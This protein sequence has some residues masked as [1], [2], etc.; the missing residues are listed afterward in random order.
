MKQVFAGNG[1][2]PLSSSWG[3]FFWGGA[4]PRSRAINFLLLVPKIYNISLRQPQ[5]NTLTLATYIRIYIEFGHYLTLYHN[6][7]LT[8]YRKWACHVKQQ[9]PLH[10]HVERLIATFH[11]LTGS[12]DW[13]TIMTTSTLLQL[14]GM[15]TWNL[16]WCTAFHTKT[17]SDRAHH[18]INCHKEC[19]LLPSCIKTMPPM[20]R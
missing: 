14:Y 5:N 11:W 2:K 3:S 6:W 8:L 13:A 12:L 15:W 7:P 9:S 20:G 19:Q 17:T 16:A 1:T 18:T 4:L 10:T